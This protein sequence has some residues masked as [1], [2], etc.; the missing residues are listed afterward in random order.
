M[1]SL[2]HTAATEPLP[3]PTFHCSLDGY[4]TEVSAYLKGLLRCIRSTPLSL[5]T[6]SGTESLELFISIYRV[7]DDIDMAEDSL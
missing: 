2:I 4:S 6:N 7:P 3:G 1:S 5:M